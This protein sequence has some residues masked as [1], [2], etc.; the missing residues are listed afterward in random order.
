MRCHYFNPFE[1][2]TTVEDEM[3]VEDTVARKK[4]KEREEKEVQVNIW[5]WYK[6]VQQTYRNCSIRVTVRGDVMF[7]HEFEIAS[8]NYYGG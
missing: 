1:C 6:F 8:M 2:V 7:K 3:A 5:F 4:R